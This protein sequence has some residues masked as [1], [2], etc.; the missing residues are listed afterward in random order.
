MSQKVGHLP[1]K[2]SQLKKNAKACQHLSRIQATTKKVWEAV[3]SSFRIMY[4][5]LLGNFC[6]NAMHAIHH[7][8]CQL[9]GQLLD[10][11]LAGELLSCSSIS[12]CALLADQPAKLVG[13]P[14][15]IQDSSSSGVALLNAFKSSLA[16]KCPKIAAVY[17]LPTVMEADLKQHA[18]VEPRTL[19][20]LGVCDKVAEALVGWIVHETK[21]ILN[22]RQTAVS[23]TV[24]NLVDN[25]L[26]HSHCELNDEQVKDL[27][28]SV[29]GPCKQLLTLFLFGGL[30]PC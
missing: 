21:Q 12:A 17:G 13:V 15:L 30:W 23:K 14:K 7:E 24:V 3:A 2:L 9:D 5:E 22:E 11:N 10:F 25:I 1:K 26:L 4:K 19:V 20:D 29:P 18:N 28:K 16:R 27:M 8:G 6:S